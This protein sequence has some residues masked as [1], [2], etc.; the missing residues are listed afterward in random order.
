MEGGLAKKTEVFS[1]IAQE[2]LNSVKNHL[3]FQVTLE[4]DPPLASP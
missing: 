2:K 1:L 4:A 3:L